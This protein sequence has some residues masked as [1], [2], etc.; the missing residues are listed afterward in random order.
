ML[1]EANE[2]LEG[3]VNALE[4]KMLL[5]EKDER[6]YNLLFYSIQE[7]QNEDVEDKFK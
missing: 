6:K 3:K 5:Q 7:E 2:K 1:R 4:N